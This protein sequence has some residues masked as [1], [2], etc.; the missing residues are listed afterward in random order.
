ML[1]IY[2]LIVFDKYTL[3]KLTTSS[4]EFKNHKLENLPFIYIYIRLHD[5]QIPIFV[6]FKCFIFEISWPTRILHLMG[7]EDIVLENLTR[8]CTIIYI[9]LYIYIHLYFRM[10]VFSLKQV[11]LTWTRITISTIYYVIYNIIVTWIYT[12]S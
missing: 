8:L 11:L 3:W 5:S 12:C 6:Q 1:D 2:I 4:H 7:Y 9:C 10:K